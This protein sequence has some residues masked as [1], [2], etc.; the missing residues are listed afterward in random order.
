MITNYQYKRQSYLCV[1]TIVQPVTGYVE[2]LYPGIDYI[3]TITCLAKGYFSSL[4]MDDLN[5]SRK[6]IT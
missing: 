2:K 5:I 4:R 6:R 1:S 3:T